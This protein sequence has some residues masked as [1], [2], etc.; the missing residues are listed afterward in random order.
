MMTELLLSTDLW[1]A[2][3]RGL[4]VTILI[5]V[6]SVTIGLVGG[7]GLALLRQFGG[8]MARAL[9]FLYIFLFRGVPLLILLYFL[10]YGVPQLSILRN[11]PLW[12]YVFS[13]PFVTCLLA[14]SL[15]NAAYLAEV[16]RGGILAIKPGEIEAGYALGLSGPRVVRRI[17]L[18][19]SLRN[20]L[21]G[22]ANET[23]F[24]IKA[25]AIASVIT[26]RDLLGEAQRFG[27][28]FSDNI[29]PLIAAGLVYV[30]LVQFV[31]WGT[32]FLRAHLHGVS[33]PAIKAAS[34]SPVEAVSTNRSI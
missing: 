12:T 30:L 17:I 29:T 6:L 19:L 28:A 7:I 26:V 16:V 22:I 5:T 8:P 24:T 4:Q 13:S 25:S 31:E 14:F 2:I 10:Y 21:G 3:L 11:G 23:I 18:P 1:L 15:N 9:A 27:T 32:R 34:S 20:C 33:R